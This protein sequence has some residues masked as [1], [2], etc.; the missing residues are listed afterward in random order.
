MTKNKVY[1]ISIV[2][3]LVLNL[4]LAFLLIQRPPHP[5]GPKHQEPKEIIIEK[6]GLDDEQIS[7][8]QLLINDHR[9][10][11]VEKEEQI[12][13]LKNE[14]YSTLKMD[15]SSDQAKK[16]IEELAQLQEDIEHIHYDHFMEIKKICKDDQLTKFN[17]VINELPK[18]FAPHHPP[19]KK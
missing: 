2:V 15:S 13:N 4:I 8:Y 7:S 12:M 14:L 19:K 17:D 5:D 1:I 11:I 6:L 18:L 10:S 16:L 3:L 9:S